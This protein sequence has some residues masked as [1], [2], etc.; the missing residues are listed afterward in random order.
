M[1][2][3]LVGRRWSSNLSNQFRHAM[4]R[5]CTPAMVLTSA[6][7]DPSHLHG[8]TLSS[9]TSLS[10]KPVPK[11]CFNLHLPSYTSSE[12]HH[13]GYCAI[14]ILPPEPNSVRLGRLFAKGVKPA[15]GTKFVPSAEAK[16]D[17]EPFHEMTTPFASLIEGVDWQFV[18][19]GDGQQVP[20]L[21]A[22]EQVFI[23]KTGQSIEEDNHEIWVAQVEQ[24]IGNT[25]HPPQGGLLYYNRDFHRLGYPLHD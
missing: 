12:L 2:A 15:H 8:M 13:N 7:S 17:G 21:I 14:H 4:S 25:R 19:V 9:V 18:T 23:C 5:I 10:V 20:V 11:V 16:V 24:I 6:T 22:S 1:V 3:L